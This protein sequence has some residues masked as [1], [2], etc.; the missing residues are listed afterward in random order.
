MIF[1]CPA[2]WE[3]I[4]A[5][6]ERCPYCDAD[7]SPFDQKQFEDKLIIALGHPVRERVRMAVRSLG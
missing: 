6:V 2:C 7:I 4:P 1:Y 3:E 5:D